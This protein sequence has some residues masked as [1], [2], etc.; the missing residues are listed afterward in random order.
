M[1]PPMDRRDFVRLLAAAPL[2]PGLQVRSGLPTLK[3]V[4][5]YPAA[6]SPGMPG[7][8]PGRVVAV[9][10]ARS[11]DIATGAANDEVVREMMARG[12]RTLTGAST[13]SDAWRKFFEP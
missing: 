9:S 1:G 7:P 4:S 11:V 8:Y 6:K 13:V 2:L 5:R 12:M 3:V 10:S